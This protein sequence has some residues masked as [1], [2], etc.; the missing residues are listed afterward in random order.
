M[1]NFETYIGPTYNQQQF[2]LVYKQQ[3]N[4]LLKITIGSTKFELELFKTQLELY[5]FHCF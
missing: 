1:V 4:V 2:N 3:Q 5:V